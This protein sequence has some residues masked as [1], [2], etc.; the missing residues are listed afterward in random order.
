M[1]NNSVVTALVFLA[2]I[3]PA[4][5]A[6]KA[7]M[8]FSQSKSEPIDITADQLD[9]LQ[10]ENKAIFT[11]HVIAVQGDVR[12]T[13]EKMTVHYKEQE[14]NKEQKAA[15]QN[16][17]EKIEVEQN[18]FL[19]TPQETAS[20]ASG[21]YDVENKKIML[22]NNVVLTKDKNTLKG[23]HLVYDFNTGKSTLTSGGKT[24]TDGKSKRV[25]AL[26]IPENGDTKKP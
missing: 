17:I 25:R 14:K 5:A 13:S 19:T 1:R 21:L 7:A 3:F 9:V 22:D 20:G 18:V 24:A 8:P 12:L 23:D 2:V 16:S 6:E 15:G 26:F 4:Y 10:N 11:G